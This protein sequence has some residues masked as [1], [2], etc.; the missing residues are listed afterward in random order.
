VNVS[1]LLIFVVVA[2]IIAYALGMILAV[3][4]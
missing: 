3:G 2:V 4:R 1:D